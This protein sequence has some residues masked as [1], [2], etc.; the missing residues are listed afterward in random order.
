MSLFTV[1][2][3]GLAIVYQRGFNQVSQLLCSKLVAF[4]I[5]SQSAMAIDDGRAQRMVHETLVLKGIFAK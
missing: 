4:E 3:V 2:G 5:G 1:R